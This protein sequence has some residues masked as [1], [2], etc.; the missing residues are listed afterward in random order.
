MAGLGQDETAIS[1]Q[2]GR[3]TPPHVAQLLLCVVV[4]QH[5]RGVSLGAFTSELLLS[6]PT[7]LDPA[8]KNVWGIILNTNFGLIDDAIAGLLPLDI[9]A[10]STVV[11]TSTAGA[12]DQARQAIFDFT[13][14]LPNATTVLWPESITGR[15]LVHNGTTGAFSLS[16]GANDGSGSAA[17]D[18]AVIA[19]GSLVWISSDG[20]NVYLVRSTPPTRQVLT[21]GT[22]ATYT[23]PFGCVRL[24]VRMVGGG[25]GG[26]GGGDSGP[27]DGT[28]GVATGF[29]GITANGG[30]GGGSSNGFGNSSPNVS[31]SGS[32]SY[33]ALGNAGQPGNPLGISGGAGGGSVF[34]G[35]GG[36]RTSDGVAHVG[37][38]GTGGGGGGGMSFSNAIGIITSAAGGG[39]GEYVELNIDN[40]AATY[41]YTVGT[42]GAGGATV[43][44]GTAG[45]AGGSGVIIVDEFYS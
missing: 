4:E 37:A 15:F 11:L 18:V 27:G 12:S 38:S 26:G 44:R 30:A 9:S 34:A 42:G 33:R 7:P 32:A 41:V 14:T 20:T 21:S 8:V 39:G 1:S 35:A 13:G 5:W 16:L 29:N 22:A 10:G 19:Q 36:T 23:T 24:A 3:L 25:G 31:G 28:I 2:D 40:P 17:G 6:Q 45:A 43:A